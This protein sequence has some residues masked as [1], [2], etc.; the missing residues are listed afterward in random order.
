[1]VKKRILHFYHS[2]VTYHYA[3]IFFVAYNDDID[4]DKEHNYNNSKTSTAENCSY[5]NSNSTAK[6]I[7]AIQKQGV[8][9]LPC[10]EWHKYPGT[11][12]NLVDKLNPHE[13]SFSFKNFNTV[14]ANSLCEC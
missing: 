3:R 14:T 9:K 10:I 8:F 7:V 11:F 2:S 4:D 1:M 13:S 12:V 5:G 6:K